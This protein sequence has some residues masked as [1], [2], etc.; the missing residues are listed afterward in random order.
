MALGDKE[1]VC[2]ELDEERGRGKERELERGKELVLGHGREQEL[3]RGKGQG[4]ERG[5]GLVLGHGKEQEL[6]RDMGLGLLDEQEQRKELE[7]DD[8]RDL[9]DMVQ[10]DQVDQPQLLWRSPQ[11][12]RT[13]QPS[14]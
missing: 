13:I 5:K 11:G 7:L 8:D 9:V 12:S 10:R 1:L 3:G 6:G 4:R 2:D 14:Y